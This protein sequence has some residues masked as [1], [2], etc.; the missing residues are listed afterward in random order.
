MRERNERDNNKISNELGS[1]KDV[2]YKDSSSIITP[3]DLL[4]DTS[5]LGDI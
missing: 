1:V 3:K 4:A 5:S 2:S